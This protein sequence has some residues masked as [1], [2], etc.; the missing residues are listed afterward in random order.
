MNFGHQNPLRLK[1]PKL[2][3]A[4]LITFRQKEWVVLKKVVAYNIMQNILGKNYEL[5]NMYSSSRLNI[6]RL[7]Y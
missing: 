3:G 1:I 4:L 7:Y 5:P 2:F 6:I